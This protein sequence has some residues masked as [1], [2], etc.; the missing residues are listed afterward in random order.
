MFNVATPLPLMYHLYPCIPCIVSMHS[1]Q[2]S[3]VNQIK[4]ATSV[5]SVWCSQRKKKSH[6][7]K[8][9]DSK[10]EK[11]NSWKGIKKKT[12]KWF[13]QKSIWEISITSSSLVSKTWSFI[14]K[15]IIFKS[16]GTDERNRC[17]ING[18]LIWHILSI[19][20]QIIFIFIC[21]ICYYRR[22]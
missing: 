1:F 9:D 18:H 17:R 11:Q 4:M 3:C 21:F 2:E 14:K 15:K 22:N 10:I 7:L 6:W 20:Y 5:I 16:N 19:W 12:S 8:Q 13:S